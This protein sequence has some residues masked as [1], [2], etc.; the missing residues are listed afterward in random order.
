VC[1]V[2]LLMTALLSVSKRCVQDTYVQSNRLLAKERGL[3]NHY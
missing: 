2:W 1:T 3:C